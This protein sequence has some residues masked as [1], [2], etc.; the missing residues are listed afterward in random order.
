[1]DYALDPF[2][3][4]IFEGFVVNIS[5]VGLCLLISNILDIGQEIILKSDIDVPSQT[6]RVEWIEKV[7][8]KHYKV[9]LIFAK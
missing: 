4:E 2:N 9:G 5:N 8:E 3:T 6:A 1:M 7:N